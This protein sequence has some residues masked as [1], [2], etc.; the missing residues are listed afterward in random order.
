MYELD[1]AKDQTMTILK[2]ALANLVMW[3]RD[4]YFPAIYAQAT[5]K[6]LEP[7][8]RLP[9][10][11]AWS[12]DTVQVELRPFND[13]RLTRDPAVLCQQVEAIRPR[14][15]DGRRFLVRVASACPFPSAAPR[16]AAA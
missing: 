7:F 2:L 16:D 11:I 4:G 9:R 14:L 15:P 8:F 1:H 12:G 5:W 3:T 6:R 10:R 13:R